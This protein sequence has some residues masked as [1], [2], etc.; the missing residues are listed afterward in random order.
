MF[1]VFLVSFYIKEGV[2]VLVAF[3]FALVGQYFFSCILTVRTMYNYF[4]HLQPSFQVSVVAHQS[5]FHFL[6][7]SSSDYAPKIHYCFCAIGSAVPA[8]TAHC[9]QFPLFCSSCI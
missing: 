9:F 2:S 3:D 8:T 1:Y 5:E 7:D 6:L 4:L